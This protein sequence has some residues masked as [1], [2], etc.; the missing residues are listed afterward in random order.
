MSGLRKKRGGDRYNIVNEQDLKN[1]CE[2][3]SKAHEEME[4]VMGQREN[5]DNVVSLVTG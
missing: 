4:E 1:A 5:G 2:F 3:V